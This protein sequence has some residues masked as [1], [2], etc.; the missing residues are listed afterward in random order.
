[1]GVSGNRRQVRET[2]DMV[3]IAMGRSS[4]WDSPVIS[5][6]VCPLSP[7]KYASEPTDTIIAYA[8]KRQPV[9]INSSVMAGVSGPISLAGTAT[10]MNAEIL[11]GA[12]L[13][14]LIH[15]KGLT[16]YGGHKWI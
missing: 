11:S 10:L 4:I 12:V 6:P 8:Q 9:Y 1:M 2:L 5:V 7:L 15:P 14:Q 3:E 13:A 16:G